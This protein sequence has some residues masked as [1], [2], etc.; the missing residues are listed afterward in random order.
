MVYEILI[1]V[2]FGNI[3]NDFGIKTNLTYFAVDVQ[4]TILLVIHD[5]CIDMHFSPLWVFYIVD[6]SNDTWKKNTN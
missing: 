3:V 5:K 1:I 2:F 6:Q 4:F